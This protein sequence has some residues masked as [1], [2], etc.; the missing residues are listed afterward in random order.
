MSIPRDAA[1]AFVHA[2]KHQNTLSKNIYNLGGG[3][4]MRVTYKEYLHRAF[5]AFGLANPDFPEHAFATRNFHCGF[6]LDS[7]D[8]E[9]ILHFRSSTK[10]DFF[11]E[12]RQSVSP[13]Q[14]FLTKLL[15]KFI[16]RKLAQQSE[17]LAAIAN[18]DTDRIKHFFDKLTETKSP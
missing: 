9:N 2:I 6:Y 14:R 16:L 4:E 1:R 7:D 3:E 13:V 17:P 11:E 15:R 5:E 10:E 8:L 18:H 12:F